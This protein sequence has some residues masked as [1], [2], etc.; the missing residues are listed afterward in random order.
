MRYF[1]RIYDNDYPEKTWFYLAYDKSEDF[2]KAKEIV[3][4]CKKEFYDQVF[5]YSL[6]ERIQEKLIEN[7]LYNT[8]AVFNYGV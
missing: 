7:N 2:N 8:I 3:D 5:D 4:T 6:Y 1:L